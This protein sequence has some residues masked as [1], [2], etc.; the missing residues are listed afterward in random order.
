MASYQQVI[1][2]VVKGQEQLAKL[3][4]RVKEL[5]KEADKLKAE[6]A[7]AGTGALAD[8]IQ[9]AATAQQALV[10]AGKQDLLNRVK[11]NAAVDLYGR[12]LQQVQTTAA[13]DQ[14]QFKGRIAD[15]QA[16]FQ[17]FKTD[18]DISGIQAVS[19]ELSRILQRSKEIQR[20]E[21][22]REKSNIRL[23][24]YINQINELKAAGLDT[25]KVERL[26]EKAGLFLGTKRFKLG[27][28]LEV[29]IKNQLGLLK[30]INRQI[31]ANNKARAK[32]KVQRGQDLALGAGFP[33]LFG[34]GAGQVLGGVAGAAL[35]GG[36]GG[37]ILGAALGQ[38][39]EDAISRTAELGRA[40]ESLDLSALADSTLLV[41]AELR[42]AVQNSIDLGESQKAVEAIA[43]ETLLQTGLFPKNIQDATNAATLLSNVW[44]ELVGSVS[45]LLSLLATPFLSALTAILSLVNAIVK[46]FNTVIGLA[47]LGIKK[48]VEFIGKLP[49]VDK[50]LEFIA[51][52][53]TG[54]NEAIEDRTATLL[55]TGKELEKE[56]D[57]EQKLFAIESRRT[58]GTDA[59]AKL[60]SARIKRDSDLLKLTLE[61]QKKIVEK[62]RE[63]AGTQGEVLENERKIQIKKI[64]QLEAIEKA[65]IE[66]KFD[67]DEQAAG[68]QRIKEIEKERQEIRA[69]ESQIAQARIQTQRN[70]LANE[71]KIFQLRQQTAAASIQLDRTR[72]D[73]QLSL[74]QLQEARLQRELDGLEKL[75][76]NFERQRELIDVIARNR[77]NQAKVENQ[78]AKVQAQQG[79]RQAQIALRQIKFQVQRINLEIQL[80]RI[81]AQGEEDDAVRQAQLRQI[82]VIAKQS[83]RLTGAMLSEGRK[84]VEIAAQIAVE[85]GKVA[86][87]ILRGRLESIEAERVEARRAVNAKEFAKATG[88][89]ADEAARL[90]RSRGRTAS[91]SMPIDPD[92]E[93]RVKASKP[94]G[95]R[96]TSELVE[97]L[98]AAQRSKN[99]RTARTPQMSSPSSS[100]F[101]SS[102][103][104]VGRPLSASR[105][106]GGTATVNVNTGPVMQVE[107]KRYVS[108]EDFESGLRQVARSTAQTSRSYGSRR[109]SGIGR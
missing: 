2:L 89:A 56:L 31:E 48:I 14:V 7:K 108:M 28:Q 22:G 23:R 41:N 71:Q 49:V 46:G 92:V 26:V 19:T 1:Q 36:F 9:E 42:E 65:R 10:N 67:L 83:R 33:L 44:D 104:L 8:T 47:G 37:Q 50:L 57:L 76:T 90:N 16:A 59:S 24:G 54:V 4:K 107:N 52:N 99:A 21:V 80:Q 32:A 109:Y 97:A 91:T 69:R 98:E 81:K 3:E 20:N 11:L 55:Q 79:V 6:P 70:E 13:A 73:A 96:N 66:N 68:Q 25:S 5:N 75:N 84:Q 94:F 30:Q 61:T 17:A 15:I 93:A 106:R 63:F 64:Q 74:L 12:R 85:Q 62:N 78:V 88:E 34:G 105:G 27:E 86:D 101:A 40:L 45:G 58:A 43:K 77:A 18:G 87:N 53:T 102:S 95:F 51:N 39:V 38:Q 82:N 103:Y 29:Q 100:S 72:L 35:G 60:N